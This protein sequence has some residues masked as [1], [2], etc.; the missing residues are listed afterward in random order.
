MM[1]LQQGKGSTMQPIEC[2]GLWW[3]P[4]NEGDRVGGTLRVSGNGELRLSLMGALGTPSIGFLRK[5]MK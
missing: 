2:N 3:L 5:T 1:N 4:D